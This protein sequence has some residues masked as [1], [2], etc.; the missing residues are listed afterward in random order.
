MKSIPLVNCR[1]TRL[2]FSGQT[3]DIT[4]SR[5]RIKLSIDP[6]NYVVI[7]LKDRQVPYKAT[8]LGSFILSQEE[9]K[10][11]IDYS[12]YMSI[13]WEDDH[14]IPELF[15]I[16]TPREIIRTYDKGKY[17]E[18]GVED[19]SLYQVTYGDGVKADFERQDERSFKFS[20]STGFY[21]SFTEQ[22]D[23]SYTLTFKGDRLEPGEDDYSSQSKFIVSRSKLTGKLLLILQDDATVCLY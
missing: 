2:V 4:R 15:F 5:N 16:E 21:G 14:S 18:L 22:A 10:G 8:I 12:K 11:L 7:G 3:F 23:G 1:A 17:I 19:V 6:D 9:R 20:F 13:H